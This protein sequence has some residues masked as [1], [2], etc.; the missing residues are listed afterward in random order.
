[1]FSRD[2]N[3]AHQASSYF[4]KTFLWENCRQIF[5]VICD[6]MLHSRQSVSQSINTIHSTSSAYNKT[7]QDRSDCRVFDNQA[8]KKWTSA[9][10]MDRLEDYENGFVEHALFIELTF[11]RLVQ[12]CPCSEIKMINGS[13]LHSNRTLLN[14]Q[15]RLRTTIKSLNF[16]LRS[17]EI[18]LCLLGSHKVFFKCEALSHFEFCCFF[19]TQFKFEWYQETRLKNSFNSWRFLSCL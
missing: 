11:T 19:S 17:L 18:D 6:V 1:M 5:Y 3:A 9:N 13:R 12:A 7:Y 10:V 4:K 8:S 15:L 14:G 16:L 2:F